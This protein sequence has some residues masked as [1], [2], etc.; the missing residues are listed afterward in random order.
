MRRVGVE[1]ADAGDGRFGEKA[2]EKTGQ[3]A[4]ARGVLGDDDQ[5]LHPPGL[6]LP[7]LGDNVIRMAP[8]ETSTNSGNGAIGAEIVAAIGDFEVRIGGAGG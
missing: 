1:K 7:R 5:F 2:A 6:Q 4:I 8:A 3:S